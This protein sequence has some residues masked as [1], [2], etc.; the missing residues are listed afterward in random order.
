MCL[1]QVSL[2][3]AL[4]LVKKRANYFEFC[5]NLSIITIYIINNKHSLNYY[6][7]I[8]D[9]ERVRAFIHAYCFRL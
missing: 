1:L 6:K 9:Y 7:R 3:Y 4:C 2:G 8:T 5:Q